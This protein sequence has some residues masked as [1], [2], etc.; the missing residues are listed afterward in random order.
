MTD[1]NSYLVDYTP[2][3]GRAGLLALPRG[4]ALGGG[5]PRPRR[6]ADARGLRR[7]GAA[8]ASAARAA[9]ADRRARPT[10]SSSRGRSM[11]AR[12]ERVVRRLRGPSRSC[13]CREFDVTLTPG[14]RGRMLRRLV[15][16]RARERSSASSSGCGP[17]TSSASSTC[18]PRTRGTLL[19]TQAATLAALRRIEARRREPAAR[20]RPQRARRAPGPARRAER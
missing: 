19:S 14:R 12:L 7:P 13:R 3:R 1:A 18:A 8:R 2:A 10:R 17:P 6:A 15:P 16:G 9:A 20:A 11:R 5:R 4:G